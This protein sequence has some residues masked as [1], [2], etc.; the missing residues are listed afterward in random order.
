MNTLVRQPKL[1]ITATAP[2]MSYVGN[3]VVYDIAIKNSGDGVA[4][5][6]DG[7]T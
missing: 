5:N 3:K 1:A 7:K 4:K 2:K 6:L